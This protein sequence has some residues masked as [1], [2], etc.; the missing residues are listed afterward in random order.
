MKRLTEFLNKTAWWVVMAMGTGMIVFVAVLAF[1]YRFDEIS[2]D[3]ARDSVLP[4]LLALLGFLLLS[5][6][7]GKL[8][9][10]VYRR[11]RF[12]DRLLLLATIALS[13][14]FSWKFLD[15]A[16]ILPSSDCQSVFEIAVWMS[17]GNMRAVVPEGSYL[18]LWPF[19]TGLIFILEKLM[20]LFHTT[21]PL[22]FQRI[23]VF[24]VGLAVLSG[25]GFLRKLTD[26]LDAVILYLA[27][28]G[29]YFPYFLN[30][31]AIY[32]DVPSLALILF[33]MWMFVLF[34]GEEK[35]IRWLYGFL[36][37]GGTVL[38]C[39]YRRNSLIF[40]IAV[41]IA[42]VLCVLEKKRWKDFVLILLTLVLS[43]SST[44]ITQKYY[45]YYA[46]NV[47]GKGVPAVAYLAMGMQDAGGIPGGWNGFHSNLYMET[48]Y[49]YEE[50]V[51]ISREA[52]GNSLAGFLE[53]P[54]SMADFYYRKLLGQWGNATCG[55]YWGLGELFRS[56]QSDFAVSVIAGRGRDILLRY[57]NLW[58][59]TVYGIFCISLAAVFA[60]RRRGEESVCWAEMV[61]LIT[62]VGGFL[63]SLIWE[64]APRYVMAYPFFVLPFAIGKLRGRGGKEDA[65]I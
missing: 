17:Q 20:R 61:P 50:T 12:L 11:F 25:Y 9:E 54:E 59:S 6:L 55:C 36:F 13:C 38:A 49:D 31:S 5:F 53:K 19:Q 44:G 8:F 56:P 42:S 16:K 15:G 51:R 45:E 27:L 46:Q 43:V 35:K 22:F 58:Q 63:F 37:F 2:S 1:L 47:C 64:A 39:T 23:N 21:E 32:G 60:R 40:V 33:S 3:N 29:T 24:Y 7:L 48:G 4:G 26:R 41:S 30:T 10:R 57:M 28:A 65:R 52:I 62:F 18:S 34:D 14:G